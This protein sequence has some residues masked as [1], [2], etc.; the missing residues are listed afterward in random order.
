M[1]DETAKDNRQTAEWIN[2]DL[3]GN[4]ELTFSPRGMFNLTV[5]KYWNFSFS[6]SALLS[7]KNRYGRHFTEKRSYAP[8]SVKPEVGGG[9]SGIGWGF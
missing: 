6:I 8:I 4:S 7:P 3:T 2:H 5:F 9:G 1:R